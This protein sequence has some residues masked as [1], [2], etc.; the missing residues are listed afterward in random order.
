MMFESYQNHVAKNKSVKK[1]CVSW[2]E[3]DFSVISFFFF[4]VIIGTVIVLFLV[5]SKVIFLS[6]EEKLSHL[7]LILTRAWL[8]YFALKSNNCAWSLI[9]F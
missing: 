4:F 3:W 5:S 9:I 7:Q 1:D 8:A 2:L 6:D